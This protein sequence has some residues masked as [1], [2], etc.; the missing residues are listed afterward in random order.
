MLVSIAT[1]IAGT[2]EHATPAVILAIIYFPIRTLFIFPFVFESVSFYWSSAV[3]HHFSVFVSGDSG[4]KSCEVL[5]CESVEGCEFG[6]VVYIPAEFEQEVP[7]TV[8]D[9]LFLFFGHGIFFEIF[10]WIFFHFLTIFFES[11]RYTEL[12]EP[13]S[14]TGL[15]CIEDDCPGYIVVFLSVMIF[16]IIFFHFASSD[17]TLPYI[18]V[19]AF[20]Y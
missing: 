5:E 6:C 16:C 20:R 1:P 8:S 12:V 19:L 7:F 18:S 15:F 9:C 3:E 13:V 14:F 2:C 17:I 10:L 11:E 4:H